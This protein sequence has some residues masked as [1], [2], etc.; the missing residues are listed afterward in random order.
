M[1]LVYSFSLPSLASSSVFSLLSTLACAC[2]LYNVVGQVLCC[3]NSIISYNMVLFGWLLYSVRCFICVL[4]SYSPL[5]QFVNMSA[6]LLEHS[7]L[8]ILRVA[9]TAINSALK[10]FCRF[11]NLTV[12]SKFLD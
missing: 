1:A 2:T 11:D 10:M 5:R 12:S 8:I 6:G 9:C 7:P 3:S 4:I